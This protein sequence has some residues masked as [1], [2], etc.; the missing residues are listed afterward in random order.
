MPRRHVL[1]AVLVTV[2]WGV[3]FVVI[4]VG[5]ESFPPL[6]F[7]ALRFALV[8]LAL[9]FVPRPGVPARWVVGVGLFMSAG[10]FGLLFVGMNEGV[11]AGL[12]SLVLQLQAA[13]TV[14]LA[15]ALLGERPRRAQLAGGALA[16]AGIGVIAAG[17]AQ[18]APLGALALVVGAALSWGVGNVCSR[19]ARAPRPLSLLVWSS[20]VPPLPLL[21]L[22]LL[23]EGPGAAGDALSGLSAGGVLALLYVVAVS[24][25][26]GYT[27]WNGLMARH[28]SSLV[29]PFTLLVPPVGIVAARVALGE[30]PGAVELAGAAV[31]LGGVALTLRPPAG[32]GAAWRAARGR[33]TGPPLRTRPAA[34]R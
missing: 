13:F 24:T 34:R 30:T 15:V 22:S 1:A 3:N 19:K 6:L 25:F 32:A 14:A 31:V 21:G 11:S 12:A 16:L 29:A 8:A 10:Q 4:H 33:P 28:P 7:A 9:P 27:V 17:R 18:G 2:A 20:L 5:L 26:G 23:T